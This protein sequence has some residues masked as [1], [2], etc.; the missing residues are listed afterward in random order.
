MKRNLLAIGLLAAAG[1]GSGAFAQSKISGSGR[2]MLETYN[3]QTSAR[4]A[5]AKDLNKTMIVT[6]NEGAS[7]DSLVALGA[8][9]YSDFGDILIIGF[10]LSRAE[11]LSALDEVK[12]IEFGASSKMHMDVAREATGI[13]AIHNGTADGLSGAAFTGKGVNVGLYDSGLDPNH[14]AFRHADGSSRVKAVYVMNENGRDNEY[15]TPEEIATFQTEDNNET[16]GTHVLGII[17]GSNDVQGRYSQT[18]KSGVLTGTIP[19]YG[20]APDADIIVGCG[21]FLNE[22]ILRGV[23]AVVKKGKELGQPTVVNLSLGSNV[24]S[25]DPNST[26]C[27]LLDRL[28][29]D[30]IICIAAGNEGENNIAVQKT[31]TLRSATL[32]TFITPANQDNANVTYFCEFWGNNSDVFELDLVVYDKTTN[33]IADKHTITNLKGNSY[34]WNQSTSSAISNYFQSGSQ[35]YVTSNIDSNTGRYYVS[36]TGLTMQVKSGSHRFGVNIRG[37][38]N[39]S[40]SGYVSA[41]GGSQDNVEFRSEG[42]SGYTPGTPDGSINEMATGKRVI[43]VGSY[44]SRV[45]STPFMNNQSYAGGGTRNDISSFS[46]YGNSS[47]GRSLPIICAPGAQIVSSI[48]KWCT[49]YAASIQNDAVTANAVLNDRDNPYYPMQGT[50]MSS[51]FVT[52]TVALWLEAFPEMTAEDCMRIITQTAIKDTYV[53]TTDLTKRRQWGNGKIDPLAGLVEALR[54]NASVEGVNADLTDNSLVIRQLAAG[55]YEVAWVG[56]QQLNVEVYSIAGARLLA[57]ATAG[58][59]ATLDTTALEP[60]V[61]VVT[62]SS[63]AGSLSRKLA[64][65]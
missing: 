46:S 48:S 62:V 36:I 56:A 28:S 22:D 55:S 52:G 9:I 25:H 7:S 18:G 42:I 24:G 30:A 38:A 44:N 3:A 59:T 40:V 6:L 19:Y 49:P 29:D 64:V 20:V 8:E 15:L 12:S 13:D 63:E 1:I 2:L 17:T 14:A 21:S 11:E 65:R 37:A 54:A 43:S 58:D 34:T 23:D 39:N 31:F 33:K 50:S 57:T 51:P 5:P 53:N 16:H 45:S 26:T 60:G 10:P 27:K 35:V 61:Y 4:K 47:D 41:A 32:N